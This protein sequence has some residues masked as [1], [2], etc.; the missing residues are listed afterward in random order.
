MPDEATII[1]APVFPLNTVLF[2]NMPLPL[3]IFEPRYKTMLTDIGHRDNRFAV[4]L[5]EEGEE[6]GGPALPYSVAC[7][8][9]VTQVQGLPGGRFLL[10]AQG[11]A[12]VRILSTDD[13]SR[14]YLVGSMQLWPE[15]SDAVSD[16]LVERAA[17]L[18]ARYA[19]D[20]MALSGE[21][22][23]EIALPADPALLSYVLGAGLQI[24][25]QLRQALLEIAGPHNR[26][27]A[28][29]DILEREGP[30]MHALAMAPMPPAE[31]EKPF[32]R[33]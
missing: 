1:T 13:A 28:E 12:R 15:E 18:F 23:E 17:R 25:A 8:A 3:Q 19:A 26:L 24:D 27:M 7:L 11:V 31:D 22:A 5:I 33:N 29:I 16:A 21:E 2:P 10:M 32:S 9:E 14:P 30:L 20:V 4:A 6:V